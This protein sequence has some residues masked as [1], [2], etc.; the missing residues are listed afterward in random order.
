LVL[1]LVGREVGVPIGGYVTQKGE[2]LEIEARFEVTHG[3]LGLTP[4]S[5]MGGALRVADPIEVEVSLV[6]N[7]A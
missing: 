7:P 1:G 4:F 3:G 5:V 2:G 6:A